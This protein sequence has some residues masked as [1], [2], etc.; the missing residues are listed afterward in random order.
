MDSVTYLSEESSPDEKEGGCPR[1]S[2]HWGENCHGFLQE[3]AF[4][5]RCLVSLHLRGL[6]M[7]W[8]DI[9]VTYS[10]QLQGGIWE[11]QIQA[12]ERTKAVL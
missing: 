3:G 7:V 6:V 9:W 4:E 10:C 2:L 11:W 1:Q 5:G 8:G 12:G